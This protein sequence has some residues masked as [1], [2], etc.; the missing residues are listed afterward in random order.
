MSAQTDAT[1][2]ILL[3][4]TSVEVSSLL[5]LVSPRAVLQAREPELRP[6][7]SPALGF[8]GEMNSTNS[9]SSLSVSSFFLSGLRNCCR[10]NDRA[11]GECFTPETPQ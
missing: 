9:T 7:S 10:F 5:A 11:A 4:G 3:Y 8:F 2:H 6:P 1:G